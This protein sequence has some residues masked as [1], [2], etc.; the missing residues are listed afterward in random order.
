MLVFCGLSF[1][2]KRGESVRDHIDRPGKSVHTA[3]CVRCF[4]PMIVDEIARMSHCL[5]TGLERGEE[6]FDVGYGKTGIYKQDEEN[7]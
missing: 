7:I 2:R 3:L 4:F 5:D 1:Q 6:V